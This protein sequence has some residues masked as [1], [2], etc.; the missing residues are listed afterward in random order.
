MLDVNTNI[1]PDLYAIINS[2]SINWSKIQGG[3]QRFVSKITSA[4]SAM[5]KYGVMHGFYDDEHE[6]PVDRDTNGIVYT[7]NSVT[8]HLCRSKVMYHD[9]VLKK[10]RLMQYMND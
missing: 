3:K 5:F 4:F 10:K 7:M 6:F 2:F 8:N 9:V 1:C